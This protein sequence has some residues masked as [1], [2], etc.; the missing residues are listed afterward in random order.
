MATKRRKQRKEGRHVGRCECGGEVR[1]V[2]QF[3]RL[4]TWCERCTPI[5]GGPAKKRKGKPR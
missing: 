2:E 1:G 3:G 5:V 4:F